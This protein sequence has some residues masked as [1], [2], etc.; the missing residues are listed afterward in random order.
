M[1]KKTKLKIGKTNN[2][3]NNNFKIRKKQN[4][5]KIRLSPADTPR[6]PP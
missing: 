5:I 6:P 4:K 3:D 2:I 1:N